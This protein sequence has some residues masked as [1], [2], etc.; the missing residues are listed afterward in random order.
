MAI[1]DKNA[2]KGLYFLCDVADTYE[3]LMESKSTERMTK[4]S[5]A[6][7]GIAFASYACGIAFRDL[8][9]FKGC[10][11]VLRAIK[12]SRKMVRLTTGE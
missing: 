3:D 7:L 9:L 8:G 1:S 10:I 11:V 6:R 2:Q 4:E 12:A 5:R